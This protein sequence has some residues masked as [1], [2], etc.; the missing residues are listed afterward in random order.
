MQKTSY[1]FP[2]LF[3]CLDACVVGTIRLA[4]LSALLIPQ[5]F[6]VLWAGGLARA[7]LLTLLTFSF[8]GSPLWMRSLECLQS[9]GVLCFLLPVYTSLLWA[10]GQSVEELWGWHCWE[11][12][13][14]CVDSL[15]ETFLPPLL[16]LQNRKW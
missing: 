5:P 15:S 10:L 8:P 16:L 9:I 6:V 11:R 3:V 4:Q 12:V 13:G 1:F 7:L 14:G 2:L